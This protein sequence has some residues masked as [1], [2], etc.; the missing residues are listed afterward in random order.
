MPPG[1]HVSE[2][3]AM[4]LSSVFAAFRHIVDYVGT[5]PV[6]AYRMDGKARVDAPLPAL[7]RRQDDPGGPGLVSWLGQAAY[8]LATG[9]AV[10]FI[11]GIDG[12]GFPAD[13]AWIHWNDW[14]WDDAGKVWRIFGQAV[15]DSQ[16]VHIPWMVPPGCKLG[17]SPIEEM[18]AVIIAGLSAQDYSDLKRGG[19][20]PPALLKNLKKTLDPEESQAVKARAVASFASGQPFVAG[21]DWDLTLMAIPPNQAQFVETLKMTANQIAAAFGIDSTELG[22]EAANSL[23]Y[24]TEELRQI[25]R[26]ANMFPYLTRIEKGLSRYLPARQFIRLNVDARM[27]ADLKTRTDVVGLQIADGRMS[28]NEARAIEDRPPVTGGDFHN[29]PAPKA[30]PTNRGEPL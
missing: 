20:I 4:R 14:Q 9:N 24:T 12:Q 26:A 13:I 19:G 2:D 16:V 17:L 1:R 29:V 15:P 30:D 3:S 28:V 21:A 10:G 5:L 22:G 23:T 27:R 8:G 6:D 18:A 25:N 11:K 7:L